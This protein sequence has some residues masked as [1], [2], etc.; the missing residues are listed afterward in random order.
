[1]NTPAPGIILVDSI[2]ISRS[3]V[4]LVGANAIAQAAG[5]AM[6]RP[7]TLAPTDSTIELKACKR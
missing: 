3:L 4:R 5:T 6:I 1:M 2:H 7:T